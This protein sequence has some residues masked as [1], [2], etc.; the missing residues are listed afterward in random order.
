MQ[1]N[2]DHMKQGKQK[3]CWGLPAM[4]SIPMGADPAQG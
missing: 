4:L 3:N 1:L 2:N